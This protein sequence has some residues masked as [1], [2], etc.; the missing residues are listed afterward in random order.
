[1]L[2]GAQR[3]GLRAQSPIVS[4]GRFNT[5]NVLVFATIAVSLWACMMYLFV[6]PS[7]HQKGPLGLQETDQL[8]GKVEQELL[9][10]KSKEDQ[11]KSDADLRNVVSGLWQSVAAKDAARNNET[12][13][14][15]S[16]WHTTNMKKCVFPFRLAENEPQYHSCTTLKNFKIAGHLAQE[17]FRNASDTAYFCA[18]SVNRHTGVTL[19]I[20]ECA[21][22]CSR[23]AALSSSHN[24]NPERLNVG[25]VMV[26]QCGGHLK[27]EVKDDVVHCSTVCS[28]GLQNT[29]QL[30]ASETLTGGGSIT[31]KW[32]KRKNALRMSE[33]ANQIAEDFFSSAMLHAPAN[34]SDLKSVLHFV[35]PSYEAHKEF[36]GGVGVVMTSG[37]KR[38]PSAIGSAMYM[39]MELH[40]NIPVEIWYDSSETEPTHELISICESQDIFLRRIPENYG[41]QRFHWERRWTRLSV[42]K[43]R[44][45][46]S[47]VLPASAVY[48]ALKPYAILLSSFDTVIF[49]DDDA[50]PI[51]DPLYLHQIMQTEKRSAVFFRDIWS[52]FHDA[53]IWSIIPFPGDNNGDHPV[54]PS[55]D[56]GVLGICKSCNHGAGYASLARTLYL[57]VHHFV[58]Y[59]ALYHGGKWSNP[60][61]HVAFGTGDKDTFQVGWLLQQEKYSLMGPVTLIGGK[62]GKCGAT[63]GQPG[64]DGRIVAIHMNSIKMSWKDWKDR[65]WEEKQRFKKHGFLLS[66]IF[67]L[68][69]AEHANFADGQTRKAVVWAGVAGSGAARCIRFFHQFSEADLPAELGYDL[70]HAMHSVFSDVFQAPWMAE[71]MRS[72]ESR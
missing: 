53:A 3:S 43:N 51:V 28:V 12:A 58:F 61:G 17:P 46:F 32:Q 54:F 9:N 36:F 15:K 71:Y 67:R 22:D 62:K 41:L 18:T 65:K 63:L 20:A 45:S 30:R 48:M 8:L 72:V 13:Q 60:G 47:E 52:L 34:E 69:K 21:D 40:S 57:N 25:G 4:R 38:L 7:G 33:Q 10:L 68:Q 35:P 27:I 1:M 37:G 6:L 70:D 55:Q 23:D 39:R 49:L 26:C 16:C 50:I 24:P 44:R 42:D 2:P 66:K 14:S 31:E 56:S 5:S 11:T 59:P 64:P 19:A 29:E